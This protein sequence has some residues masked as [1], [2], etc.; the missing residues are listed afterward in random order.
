[1]RLLNETTQPAKVAQHEKQRYS[2]HRRMVSTSSGSVHDIL[3]MSRLLHVENFNTDTNKYLELFHVQD[4]L[5]KARETVALNL[6][7]VRQMQSESAVKLKLLRYWL[8]RRAALAQR[9][10]AQ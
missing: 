1:M 2:Q 9:I 5:N 8:G 7:Y 6:R 3:A 4:R 10:Q